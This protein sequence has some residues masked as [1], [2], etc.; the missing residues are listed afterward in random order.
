MFSNELM[1]KCQQ[2]MKEYSISNQPCLVYNRACDLCSNM[3]MKNSQ[4]SSSELDRLKSE[5][6]LECDELKTAF[7]TVIDKHIHEI[8]KSYEKFSN[9]I[10]LF[11]LEY[12]ERLIDREASIQNLASNESTRNKKREILKL[13]EENSS[14]DS[15]DTAQVVASVVASKFK[16]RKQ[17]SPF[18]LLKFFILF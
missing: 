1:L 3:S 14:S 18:F 10:E 2:C 11:K 5:A 15:S 17:F 13:N 8:N 12:K 9:Q 7:K 16:Q 6:D 4:L